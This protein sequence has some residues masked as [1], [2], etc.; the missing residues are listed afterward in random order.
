[1]SGGEFV[2]PAF[3]V[4][5]DTCGCPLN[6]CGLRPEGRKFDVVVGDGISTDRCIPCQDASGVEPRY[7]KRYAL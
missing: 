3:I 2:A 6:L 4:K 1:M 7:D 5:C